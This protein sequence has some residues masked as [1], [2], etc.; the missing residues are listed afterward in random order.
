[1]AKIQL[2]CDLR[3]D[4]GVLIGSRIDSG[5]KS[6]RTEAEAAIATVIQ[7]RVDAANGAA[8]E[9]QQAQSAFNS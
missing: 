3:T 5:V 2:L 9:L 4:A 8:T 7:Q 1:M 6:S